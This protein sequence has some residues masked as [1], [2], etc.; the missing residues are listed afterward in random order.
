M[1]SKGTLNYSDFKLVAYIVIK[2]HH[3]FSVSAAKLLKHIVETRLLKE[4]EFST[5]QDLQNKLN[6]VKDV[7][8]NRIEDPY[9]LKLV[10]DDLNIIISKLNSVKINTSIDRLKE[11]GSK[12]IKAL[13]HYFNADI[14]LN[15]DVF[16]VEYFPKPYDK[17]TTWDFMFADEDD[18]EKYDIDVGL[19][20]H[21]GRQFPYYSEVL[22]I[23]EYVHFFFNELKPNKSE[24]LFRWLEE[25]LADW[26]AFKVHYDL[27]KDIKAIEFSK[28]MNL[29]YAESFPYSTL[30]E[31]Q[32][33]HDIFQVIFKVGGNEAIINLAKK[34]VENPTSTY[35]SKLFNDVKNMEFNLVFD[36]QKD[37]TIRD[38][39]DLLITTN[40]QEFGLLNLSSIEYII[41]K[42]LNNK[43]FIGEISKKTQLQDDVLKSGL[44]RLQARGFVL[45]TQDDCFEII[46]GIKH[47]AKS[48]LIKVNYEWKKSS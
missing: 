19:Y 12:S 8:R 48:E 22:I 16:I 42:K 10:E 41:L 31:Y 25:G 6:E 23:H 1:S 24:N 18:Y 27:F 17:I 28:R 34:Y 2:E 11:I 15:P 44:E 38:K 7:L 46:D 36:L 47:I 40:S 30:A 35:W 39:L 21:T 4:S 37:F 14:H 33:Y 45:K 26:F 13:N 20:I 29:L 32:G 5:K 3:I 43:M 9:Y